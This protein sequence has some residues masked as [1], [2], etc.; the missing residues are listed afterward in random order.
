[1]QMADQ[2]LIDILQGGDHEI[3]LWHLS[4]HGDSIKKKKNLMMIIGLE[5]LS[6]ELLKGLAA[7]APNHYQKSRV[8]PRINIF[9]ATL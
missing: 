5:W 2:Y 9:S 3:L 4:N 8:H 7:A 6:F 1:M